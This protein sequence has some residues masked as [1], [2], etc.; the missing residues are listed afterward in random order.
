MPEKKASTFVHDDDFVDIYA[1]NSQFESSLW[2]LRIT[3]GQT[4]P[5]VGHDGVL[6]HTAIRIP[7]PQ[8]KVMAYFLQVNILGHEAEHGRIPLASGLIPEFPSEPPEA[9][10]KEHPEAADGWVKMRQFYE[11]FITKNPDVV[12]VQK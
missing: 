4:D 2:D 5:S 7:W 11:D 10:V 3:F 6:Q 9:L 12:K 8:A 1:N